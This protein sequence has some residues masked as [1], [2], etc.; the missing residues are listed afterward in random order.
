MEGRGREGIG[1]GVG[2]GNIATGDGNGLGHTTGET[3]GTGRGLARDAVTDRQP[4]TDIDHG[5]GIAMQDTISTATGLQD[6][7]R[8]IADTGAGH[9]TIKTKEETDQRV[10]IETL[11]LELFHSMED[12]YPERLPTPTPLRIQFGV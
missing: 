6:A 3:I 10:R 12:P 1:I 2:R 8:T 9:R 5:P 7:S 11:I 4:G